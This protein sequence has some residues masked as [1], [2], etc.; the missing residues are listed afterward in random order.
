MGFSEKLSARREATGGMLCVGLDPDLAKLPASVADTPEPLFEFC[1]A[2]V[3]ATKPYAAAFKPN[4]GFFE[5]QGSDGIAE[6]EQLLAEIPE[7][8]PVI[9]EKHV[10]HWLAP[11]PQPLDG[12]QLAWSA[13]LEN[14]KGAHAALYG[15]KVMNPRP[16]VAIASIDVLPG[17][18]AKGAPANRAVP[19]LLAVTLGM[20][21]E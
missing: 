4:L 21:E 1:R 3:E 7:E 18:D 10:D 11:A 13:A 6:L 8:I 2:I 16:V 20:I 14:V 12:A 17:R 5:A 19:A 15:M 9:L